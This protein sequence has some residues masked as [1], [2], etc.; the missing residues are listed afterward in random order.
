MSALFY[1]CSVAMLTTHPLETASNQGKRSKIYILPST[2]AG[3]MWFYQG[4]T[5][6]R[7]GTKAPNK[8]SRFLVSFFLVLDSFTDK[9][10][11]LL[12]RLGAR[13]EDS[14]PGNVLNETV[15]GSTSIL[16]GFWCLLGCSQVSWSQKTENKCPQKKHIINNAETFE[17]PA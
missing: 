4:E 16:G 13:N 14:S 5:L 17:D 3:K 10:R 2:M 1:L 12:A 9:Y 11:C 6:I 15:D 8:R 7:T